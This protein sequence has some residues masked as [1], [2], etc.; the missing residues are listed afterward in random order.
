MSKRGLPHL[1]I[2][3]AAIYV[4]IVAASYALATLG[5]GDEFG[6]RVIPFLMLAMPWFTF[7]SH[8]STTGWLLPAIPCCVLNAGILFVAGRLI[9]RRL[10]VVGAWLA[11]IYLALVIA[12]YVLS[13]ARP[14]NVG[15]DWTFVML[16]MP[17]YRV[18]DLLLITGF[19][20][21]AGILY[22]VGALIEKQRRSV[23]KGDA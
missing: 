18:S 6:Y 19:I 21:N 7:V 22:L 10:S 16:A 20:L 4:V 13:A 9:G 8:F 23:A 2:W 17:W 15:L 3:F 12:I 11:S 14:Y 1:G 5:K